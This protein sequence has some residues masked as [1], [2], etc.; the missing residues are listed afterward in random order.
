MTAHRL[1]L[2]ALAIGAASCSNEAALSVNVKVAPGVKARCVRVYALTA[3]GKELLTE[4]MPRGDGELVVAVFRGGE[5]DGE[6]TLGARGYLGEA[7]KGHENELVLNEEGAPKKAS[8]PASGVE[9]VELTLDGVPAQFDED[10]DGYRAQAHSGPDCLDTNG[11]VH[12]EAA[13]ACGDGL[14]NDC[15]NGA[16]CADPGCDNQPCSDNN[17]CTV[18]EICVQGAC[19]QAK[20]VVCDVPPSDECFTAPGTCTPETGQCAFEVKVGA[21]CKVGHCNNAGACVDSS[22]EVN[23]ADGQDDDDN[24]LIDCADPDCAQQ[25]CNDGMACNVGEIC[26]AGTCGGGQPM[27]CN[28][29]PDLCW[30]RAG[31]CQPGNGK[32]EY[33]PKPAGSTCDVGKSCA[34]N[35]DCVPEEAECANGK[36]DDNDGLTDCADPG[37]NGARCDDKNVCTVDETCS[38]ATSSCQGGTTLMC[39]APPECN[40]VPGTCDPTGGCAYTPTPDVACSIGFCS[41]AGVCEPPFPFKPSNFDPFAFPPSVRG[42]PYELNCTATLQVYPTF[43]STPGIRQPFTNWCANGGVPPPTPQV[44]TL[45]NG[46]EAVVLPMKGLIIRK[47]SALRLTGTRP[48]ILAVY[49]DVSIEGYLFGGALGPLHGPGGGHAAICGNGT[50]TPGATGGLGGGGG[51]GGFGSAGG[52]G[53][54]GQ[55]LTA[56]GGAGVANGTATLVPLRGGCGGGAGG[57][58]GGAGGGGGGAFQISA[59]GRLT[60]TGLVGAPGGGGQGATAPNGAGG[61]GGGGGAIV[62]EGN[63]L[64]FAANAIISASGGAGGEGRGPSGPGAGDGRN[65]EDGPFFVAEVAEGGRGGSSRG[66]DGG[67]GAFGDSV[68]ART[69]GNGDRDGGEGGAGGGGGGGVGR[70]RVNVGSGTCSNAGARFLPS[71]ASGA[72]NCP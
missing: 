18:E 49:G 25:P 23:C 14:D 43:D 38:A 5:L 4:A 42:G 11:A 46:S 39:N 50:G 26:G 61:G 59:S 67:D 56:G 21:P 17:A 45:S 28:S 1:L 36:D 41:K 15:R 53:G 20:P 32:C 24:G 3:S 54:A 64:S 33:T 65:G 2:A 35:G 27:T 66:G 8:F 57:N 58:G 31:V 10:R 12:P 47:Q 34:N 19:E 40:A 51:G 22:I 72:T 63:H 37:C 6:L 69:G 9:N 52:V 29:P 68:P 13:E 60:V 55:D 44:V 70:I 16:D 48:V 30:E 7:C 62:L 71:P